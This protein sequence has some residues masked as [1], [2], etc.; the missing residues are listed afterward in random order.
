MEL[1]LDMSLLWNRMTFAR[2]VSAMGGSVISD[3]NGVLLFDL[4]GVRM[5]MDVG[6]YPIFRIGAYF[7]IPPGEKGAFLG[8]ASRLSASGGSVEV[9][10]NS[11]AGTAS[12]SCLGFA[13]GEKDLSENLVEITRRI[14]NAASVLAG[15]ARN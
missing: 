8:A 13:Y 2:S 3:D 1:G 12:F 14:A 11:L 6:P 10:V 7:T 9:K 15:I 4:F 5:T